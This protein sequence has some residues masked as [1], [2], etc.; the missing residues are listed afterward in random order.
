MLGV[1][2]FIDNEAYKDLAH[3]PQE[4]EK[5]LKETNVKCLELKNDLKKKD[6][7]RE[8]FKI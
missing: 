1:L 6:N 2:S 4:S 7:E 3:L 5:E 8:E